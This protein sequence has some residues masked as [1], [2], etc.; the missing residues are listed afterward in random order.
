[1]Y[2]STKDTKPINRDNYSE[3]LLKQK[4]TDIICCVLLRQL[5]SQ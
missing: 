5:V 2:V 4:P 3:F 1:M